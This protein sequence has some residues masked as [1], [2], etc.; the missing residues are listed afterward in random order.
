MR[1]SRKPNQPL[2]NRARPDFCTGM[3]RD[4]VYLGLRLGISVGPFPG[5]RHGG[6][7][8]DL[9]SGLK[10]QRLERDGH[11]YLRCQVTV[12]KC[13]QDDVA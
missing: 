7:S 9:R 3:A 4:F 8:S 2:L 6:Q 5:K 13:D 12:G 10:G 11:A 1:L